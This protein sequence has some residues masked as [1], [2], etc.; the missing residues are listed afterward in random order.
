MQQIVF[1]QLNGWLMDSNDSLLP[2]EFCELNESDYS[3][4]I[5]YLEEHKMLVA[6]YKKI[7]KNRIPCELASFVDI[8]AS[9]VNTVMTIAR[10]QRMYIMKLL[11]NYEGNYVVLKGVTTEVL[12]HNQELFRESGDWDIW[13]EDPE[14][15]TDFALENG[16]LRYDESCAPHE[17]SKLFF[18]KNANVEIEVHQSFPNICIPT[19]ILKREPATKAGYVNMN[20]PLFSDVSQ[21]I[22]QVEWENRG[23][24]RVFS[25]EMAVILLCMNTFKDYLWEPYKI[26]NIRLHDLI[27]IQCLSSSQDFSRSKFSTLVEKYGCSQAVSFAHNLLN[28]FYQEA[29]LPYYPVDLRIRK[30]MNDIYSLFTVQHSLDFYQ[31]LCSETF[32]QRVESLNPNHI[33]LLTDLD[34]RFMKTV[35]R[36]SAE[37]TEKQF[38]FKFRF[39]AN[40]HNLTLTYVI[41][42]AI[43]EK[44][45]FFVIFRNHM[46]HLHIHKSGDNEYSFESYGLEPDETFNID[47]TLDS[48]TIRFN[49]SHVPRDNILYSV[50]AVEKFVDGN[51]FQ[52]IVPVVIHGDY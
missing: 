11:K 41:N 3:E 29:N 51:R 49:F 44:D 33:S 37:R 39:S 17:F 38:D 1:K 23:S 9:E 4:V 32:A 7:E 2:S 6:F 25:K 14:E 45:N 46:E 22:I 18:S 16:Y 52:T 28:I 35:Y 48:F 15:F 8:V 10:Q 36:S 26:P 19:E 24:I 21:E 40:D 12:T 5:E 20:Y 30:L 50:I 31:D 27:E 42:G 34:S 47:E 13:A 43:E